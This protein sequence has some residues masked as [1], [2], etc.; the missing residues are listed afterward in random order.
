MIVAEM[1]FSQ[2]LSVCGWA[3]S[4]FG[5]F[6]F[7]R[8]AWQALSMRRWCQATGQVLLSEMRRGTKITADGSRLYEPILLYA[9]EVNSQTFESNV[10]D[11]STP[12]TCDQTLAVFIGK[13]RP[14]AAVRVY[15]HPSNPDKAA[16]RMRP[17]RLPVVGMVVCITVA[18]LLSLRLA[19][20]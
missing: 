12:P 9:Y 3:L 7:G 1:N 13:H 17:W 4:S 6:I 16:L 5:V 11:P 10:F 14:G 15:H 20:S 19:N 18:V 2:T 8:R